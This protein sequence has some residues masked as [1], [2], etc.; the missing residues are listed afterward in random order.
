MLH[1]KLTHNKGYKWFSRNNVHVK[2]YI[3]TPDN[4]L[5]KDG[6]LADYF[7][8]AQTLDDFKRKLQQANGLYAVVIQKDDRTLCAVDT[9]RAFPLF[10]YQ[11]DG[12]LAITDNPDELASE[13]IPLTI[14][15]TGVVIMQYAGF[16]TGSRTL[17][18][19]IFQI[20]AGEYICFANNTSQKEFHTRFL[21][22]TLFSLSRNELKQALK[23]ALLKVGE[24][25]VKALDGRTAVIPLS[26]GFD[27][28]IIAYLLKKHNY[29]S[30][31]CYTYG[32]SGNVELQNARATAEKLGFDWYFVEYDEFFNRKMNEEPLFKD[33]THFSACYSSQSAE[34]DYFGMEKLFSLNKIP[35]N[36][37]FIPGHSGVIA[38]ELVIPEMENPAFNYV[39]YALET[40]FMQL[41]PRKKEISIIQKEI[42]SLHNELTDKYPPYL[43]YENWRFR[44]TTA[45]FGHNGA[46]I[47]DF[48]G[49]EYLLPLWDSELFNFFVKVPSQYKYSKNLYKETLGEMFEEYGIS[50]YKDE[51]IPS[52]KLL[53][54]VAF[55]S[56]LKK[57][58][59]ILKMFI[60]IWRTDRT[61]A[62][63]F[64][65]SFVDELKKSGF[66]RKI[67]NINGILSAWYLL[68]VK[69]KMNAKY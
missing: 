8:P 59:P 5:L 6:N 10:Y 62:Q 55:R 42:D 11:N 34:Q 14:D 53:R 4:R 35:A 30:V 51:L 19:N 22:E 23:Q 29:P 54:K 25:L 24:H 69:R 40:T 50:F 2:G 56:K 36:A 3:L 26:G 39:D 7:L 12:I 63:F 65:Q 60:N 16:V 28:R 43:A 46:K 18:K 61:G 47:W 44:E 1:I 68:Q 52:A 66:R 20:Q 58:F 31:F 49:Y 37:V 67:T 13:N 9:T 17:L 27:S 64:L 38:G 33:Y 32:K 41:F 48:F 21:S 45:K 15:E 57:N